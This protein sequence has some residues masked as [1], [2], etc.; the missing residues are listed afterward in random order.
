MRSSLKP[1]WAS[2]FF[3]CSSKLASRK[4]FLIAGV[5]PMRFGR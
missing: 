3:I 2:S 5:A 1:S 4:N